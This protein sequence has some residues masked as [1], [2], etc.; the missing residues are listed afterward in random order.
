M[1]PVSTV[2]SSPAV[3][4][5]APPV[6]N[7]TGVEATSPTRTLLAAA[8]TALTSGAKGA[9]SFW[10]RIGKGKESQSEKGIRNLGQ[11]CVPPAGVRLADEEEFLTLNIGSL[12]TIR[13][14]KEPTWCACL[15]QLLE[16]PWYNAFFS[17]LG[18][19]E[20]ELAF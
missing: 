7:S 15:D 8:G 2:P 18:S 17:N 14:Q 13:I 3:P 20:A 9:G 11:H 1:T 6:V 5:S 10:A 16:E 4:P 12:R 19:E